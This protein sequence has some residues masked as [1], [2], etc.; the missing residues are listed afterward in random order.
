M[1]ILHCS[2]IHYSKDAI[3]WI[4]QNRAS[5]DVVCLTGDFLDDRDCAIT[6]PIEQ[7]EFFTKWF[8]GFEQPLFVC[9]GNHDYFNGSL[10]WLSRRNGLKGDGT[11]CLL[12]GVKFGCISYEDDNFEYYADCDVVLYHVPPSGTS[13]AKE[14]NQNFG[15]FSVKNAL[16]H[17]LKNVKYLLCGHVHR[18]AKHAIRLGN[19][20]VSN[21]GGIHKNNQASHA[22]IEVK[23]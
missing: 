1:K 22:I 3:N 21:A 14:N 10:S 7:I 8:D 6:T 15:C 16:K 5:Y 11:R 2:D 13:C 9:S 4:E 20:I 17:S 18:P 19:V 23:V 12:N